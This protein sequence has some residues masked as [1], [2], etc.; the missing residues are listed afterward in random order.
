MKTF[1]TWMV[2]TFRA[3]LIRTFLRKRTLR[4]KKLESTFQL[5][6]VVQVNTSEELGRFTYV[7]KG[8]FYRKTFRRHPKLVISGPRNLSEFLL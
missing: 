3:W 6:D 7:G 5:F 8:L 2:R 4:L 1:R